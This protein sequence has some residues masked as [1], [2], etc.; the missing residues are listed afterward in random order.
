MFLIFYKTVVF[1]KI[2]STIKK[3]L[4]APLIDVSFEKCW[5]MQMFF[6]LQKSRQGHTFPVSRSW[7]FK[8]KGYIME[9]IWGEISNIS[10]SKACNSLNGCT[11]DPPTRP[12]MF[13]QF[14]LGVCS[15]FWKKKP[16]EK[17]V[18]AQVRCLNYHFDCSWNCVNCGHWALFNNAQENCQSMTNESIT[19]TR[20]WLRVH[21]HKLMKPNE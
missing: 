12:C 17:R 6:F 3:S 20:K 1:N 21:F 10:I 4:I 9:G 16:L 19:S 8:L 15:C 11:L 14:Y 18:I 13:W 7:Y 2:A 5:K